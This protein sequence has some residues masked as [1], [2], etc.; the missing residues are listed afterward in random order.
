MNK[1]MVGYQGWTM[2]RATSSDAFVPILADGVNWM[3]NSPVG[4]FLWSVGWFGDRLSADD[5][6]NKFDTLAVAR[7][8]WLRLAADAPC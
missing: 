6:F 3:G 4:S 8:V 1:I 2:E 5:S 7:G